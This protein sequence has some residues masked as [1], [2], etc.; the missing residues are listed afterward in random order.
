MS[1]KKQPTNEIFGA[2]EKFTNAFFDSLKKGAADR[3][4]AKAKAK[5]VK[6]EAIQRMEK[7]KREKEQL[8]TLLNRM[9]K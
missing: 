4:I 5:G 3:V 2:A 8:D 7:I 9:S 1:K 6:P